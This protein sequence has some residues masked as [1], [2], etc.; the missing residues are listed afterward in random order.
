MGDG[1]WQAGGRGDRALRRPGHPAAGRRGR[2][3]RG[4]PP[5]ALGRLAERAE[6]RVPGRAD[7]DDRRR[8]G[9]RGRR[10][11]QRGAARERR[12]CRRRSRWSACAS[13]DRPCPTIASTMS[14]V[15]LFDLVA[16]TLIVL[17]V[18]LS[19]ALPISLEL[20]IS[21]APGW[22]V[23]AAVLTALALVLARRFGQ[24]LRR[25]RAQVAQGGAI[26][27][28]PGRYARRVALVQAGAWAMPDRRR[29]LPAGGLRTRRDRAARRAGD[30]PL[31]GVDAR[32]ADAGRGRHPAGDARLRAQPGG[33]GRRRSCRS[34][35]A[36]R[37]GSRRSTPCWGLL[38][39]DGGLQDAAP[40]A[41][42]S[43]RSRL[44][45]ANTRWRTTA[46][47]VGSPTALTAAEHRC[48]AAAARGTVCAWPSPPARTPPNAALPLP[49][50]RC[51]SAPGSASASGPS[52]RSSTWTSRSTPGEVVALVGDNGA[53]KST[54]IK[55][56]AGTQ[57]ADSGQLPLR[58]P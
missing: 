42:R 5:A 27:R 16:A 51:S 18:G 10:R 32:T 25:L 28:T 55:A 8:L 40:A 15:V 1:V 35:S 20:P 11:P 19:G 34:R 56:I 44:A 45:R 33:V 17:T 26:L 12:R 23:A 49:G 13:E 29:L 41:G 30:D 7:R 37:R 50:P 14:V 22:I 9:V 43:I 47:R 21:G 48:A 57:P 53:G 52:R 36:C 39:G 31:R 6:R 2:V 54:L 46:A 38:A 58:G 24:P 3:P 4:Q